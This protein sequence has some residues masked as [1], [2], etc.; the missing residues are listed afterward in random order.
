MT[1]THWNGSDHALTLY[2]ALQ[3]YEWNLSPQPFDFQVSGN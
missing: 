3:E 1:H 2:E